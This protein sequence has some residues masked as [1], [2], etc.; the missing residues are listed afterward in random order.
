MVY[1]RK[2]GGL[3]KMSDKLHEYL[4]ERLLFLFD[5]SNG[6]FSLLD[7]CDDF[8][9][10]AYFMVELLK[11]YGRI[12]RTIKYV[13]NFS[14]YQQRANDLD[15]KIIDRAKHDVIAHIL[16]HIKERIKKV[17]STLDDYLNYLNKLAPEQIE[18]V[19]TNMEISDLALHNVI[20]E[21]DNIGLVIEE[22]EKRKWGSKAQIREVKNKL[23][24]LD[25]RLKEQ[26]V[27]PP[28][29]KVFL[30]NYRA[31]FGMK[32]A[33]KYWWLDM[34]AIDEV[35]AKELA[36]FFE[37]VRAVKKFYTPTKECKRFDEHII[38]GYVDKT[39]PT[40]MRR[41]FEKH[42]K[43]CNYCLNQVLQVSHTKEV[44]SKAKLS[45]TRELNKIL[46]EA[47]EKS[48]RA[49]EEKETLKELLQILTSLPESPPYPDR[50]AERVEAAYPATPLLPIGAFLISLITISGLR[51]KALAYRGK[52]FEYEKEKLIKEIFREIDS[53]KMLY[54]LL[55][56]F[57]E[58]RLEDKEIKRVLSKLPPEVRQEF[59][60]K[61]L[62]ELL[63]QVPRE[64][65]D[66]LKALLYLKV[67]KWEKAK[68]S[69]IN[70][71]GSEQKTLALRGCIWSAIK[72]NRARFAMKQAK[73]LCQSE[74]MSI[75]PHQ[76]LQEARKQPPDDF[77][78]LNVDQEISLKI[79]ILNKVLTDLNQRRD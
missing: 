21:R 20:I 13:S 70:L 69:F 35:A 40:D 45:T 10:K 52:K 2:L 46:E 67:G 48:Q 51:P 63:R 41:E 17:D 5:D 61:I 39:L 36:P 74:K 1:K 77:L 64:D 49:K 44:F 34:K 42:L 50:V 79:K 29:L 9:I 32:E 56:K 33:G 60:R 47:K 15:K 78:R 28:G 37:K 3:E 12:Q 76:I 54:K 31:S 73:V 68:D 19:E 11:N 24:R 14:H 7:D 58:G 75:K 27:L 22:I 57:L 38:A 16:P 30:D 25:K 62:S 18:D 66:L 55:L 71:L 26:F 8:S 59:A 43:S 4:K 23:N 53:P 6:L 72:A 65:L